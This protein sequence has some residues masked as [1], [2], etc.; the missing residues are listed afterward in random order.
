M[1]LSQ[2]WP[3]RRGTARSGRNGSRQGRKQVTH[4]HTHTHTHSYTLTHTH[5]LTHIHTYTHIHNTTSHTV[6]CHKCTHTYTHSHNDMH[7]NRTVI[8]AMYSIYQE[9]ILFECFHIEND[10]LM[11]TCYFQC[12]LCFTPI[13]RLNDAKCDPSGRLWAGTMHDGNP[14]KQNEG[15]LYMYSKGEPQTCHN[16]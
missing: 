9:F 8:G 13:S 1:N 2:Y 4:T 12:V 11:H 3:L 16:N 7:T 14:L 5:T 10:L 6:I 15:S